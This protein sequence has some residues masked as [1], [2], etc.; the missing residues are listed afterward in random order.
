M[1]IEKDLMDAMNDILE[2]Y[3]WKKSEQRTIALFMQTL[4]EYRKPET[5]KEEVSGEAVT[6]EASRATFRD[7]SDRSAHEA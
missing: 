6:V 1:K 5:K 3:E 2:N 7:L 4:I